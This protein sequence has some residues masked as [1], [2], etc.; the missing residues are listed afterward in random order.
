MSLQKHGIFFQSQ[1]YVTELC[2]PLNILEFLDDQVNQSMSHSLKP[3]D[4][5]LQNKSKQK[6]NLHKINREIK[7]NPYGSRWA[8]KVLEK[9]FGV[10][11]SQI[12]Q[13]QRPKWII[14]KLK[15]AESIDN[16]N[17]KNSRSINDIKSEEKLNRQ[18]ISKSNSRRIDRI[19]Q[20]YR[21]SFSG[22]RQPLPA[23]D[24]NYFVK[25]DQFNL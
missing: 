24:D 21:Q 16:K 9:Q 18:T 4:Q 14:K 19:V 8:N 13:R 11:L 1:L 23:L 7:Q 15:P 5:E 20:N 17:Q 22:I 25:L 6:D 12:Q 3:Q 10:Y 2:E